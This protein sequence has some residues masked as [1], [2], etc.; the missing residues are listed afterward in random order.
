MQLRRLGYCL[1][2]A[3]ILSA[4]GCKSTPPN[5]NQ[6]FYVGTYERLESPNPIEQP[7]PAQP[8]VGITVSGQLSPTFA[9]PADCPWLDPEG[10]VQVYWGKTGSAVND[11][12]EL[13]VYYVSNAVAPACW[14]HE[15][16]FP[17]NECNAPLPPAYIASSDGLENEIEDD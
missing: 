15:V 7:G 6:G 13:G 2:T 12:D 9:P 1:F 8:L 11:P 16:Y 4:A 3:A 10:S 14:N 17:V 5:P